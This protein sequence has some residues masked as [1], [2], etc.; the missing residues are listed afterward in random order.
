MLI[1]PVSLHWRMFLALLLNGILV[2]SAAG[3]D[4]DLHRTPDLTA[5]YLGLDSRTEFTFVT[6][7][8]S[9]TKPIGLLNWTIPLSELATAGLD[10]D[11]VSYCAEPTVPVLPNWPW[12]F[13]VDPLERPKNYPQ[14][15]VERE[16]ALARRKAQFL[17][18]LYGKHY[19]DP[20]DE[21]AQ[22]GRAHV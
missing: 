4:S 15:A 9:L 20:K 19:P 3:D 11:F 22:I 18:E 17:R 2:L 1:G 5:L 16:K 21:D 12:S 6:N 13:A 10:R 7:E 14:V 8:R